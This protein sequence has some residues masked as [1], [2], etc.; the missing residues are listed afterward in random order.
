MDSKFLFGVCVWSSFKEIF[1]F[2]VFSSV[3]FFVGLLCFLGADAV[4]VRASASNLS[5]AQLLFA[6]KQMAGSGAL[7]VR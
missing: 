5:P 7:A 6:E 3:V 2:V 1:L 4:A